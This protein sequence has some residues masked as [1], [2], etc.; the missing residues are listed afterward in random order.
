MSS[1]AFCVHIEWGLAIKPSP[2]TGAEKVLRCA[3]HSTLDC[4][5]VFQQ[6]KG[7]KN[8]SLRYN[9]SSMLGEVILPGFYLVVTFS[10]SFKAVQGPSTANFSPI[11]DQFK[12]RELRI[13]LLA[14]QEIFL[15]QRRPREET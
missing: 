10:S 7:N 11:C 9:T 2:G 1:L 6:A 12:H 14:L 8:K 15:L 4:V 3:F 5:S 13:Q